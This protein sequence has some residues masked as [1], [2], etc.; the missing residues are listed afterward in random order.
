[1][2][3][4]RKMCRFLSEEGDSFGIWMPGEK[5]EIENADDSWDSDCAEVN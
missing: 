1:M 3:F 4:V 2:H 5:K